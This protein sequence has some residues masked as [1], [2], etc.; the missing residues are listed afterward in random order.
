[1]LNYGIECLSHYVPLHSSPYGQKI[2][3]PN[4]TM[5]IT[6]SISKRIMR[7][8]LWIGL[9]ERQDFIIRMCID[10]IIS[11]KYI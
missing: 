9:N 7:L 10:T 4:G 1:M 2:G 3:R 11:L 8:P 6:E 5:S